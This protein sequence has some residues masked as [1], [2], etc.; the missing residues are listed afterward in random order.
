MVSR[1]AAAPECLWTQAQRLPLA[2]A[3]AYWSE[4][5][6]LSRP[7]VA[8]LS[9]SVVAWS[10]WLAEQSPFRLAVAWLCW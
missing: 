3:L 8:W 5:M 2:V 1:S 10:L 9:P 6:L 7:V 4:Q